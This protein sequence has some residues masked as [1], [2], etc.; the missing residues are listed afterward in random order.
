MDNDFDFFSSPEVLVHIQDYLTLKVMR[1][2][3]SA[4]A[5]QGVTCYGARSLAKAGGQLQVEDVA[6]LGLCGSDGRP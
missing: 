2:N 4:A 5:G 6:V 3:P 1:K